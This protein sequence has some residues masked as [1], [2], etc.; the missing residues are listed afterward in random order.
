MNTDGFMKRSASLN[1]SYQQ[2]NFTTL[3]TA[4]N[5]YT[6]FLEKEKINNRELNFKGKIFSC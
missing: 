5:F 6:R 2:P 3:K 4:S 1:T